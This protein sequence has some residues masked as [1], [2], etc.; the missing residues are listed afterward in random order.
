LE[1]MLL[2]AMGNAYAKGMNTQMQQ[3][4]CLTAC[5]LERYYLAHGT[6]PENL[7]ALVPALIPQLS[8]D[9]M[10]GKPLIYRRES[11]AAFILYSVGQ[12]LVDDGGTVVMG[13]GNR[14]NPQAGDWVWHQPGK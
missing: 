6:Y 5:G 10:S 8:K 4:L 12:N 2:P 11:P 1:F 9:L 13:K 7:E 3:Q 14:I